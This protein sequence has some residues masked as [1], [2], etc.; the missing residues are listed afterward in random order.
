[1]KWIHNEHKC[2]IWLNL[3]QN[4][5]LKNHVRKT[6]V[7]AI[8]THDIYHSVSHYVSFDNIVLFKTAPNSRN[9]Y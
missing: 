3:K 7:R 2:N 6:Q 8:S 4:L 1:M 5:K 9:I